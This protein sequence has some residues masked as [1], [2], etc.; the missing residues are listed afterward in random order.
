MSKFFCDEVSVHGGGCEY[1]GDDEIVLGELILG[2]CDDVV[3]I[4]DGLFCEDL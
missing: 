1:G 3:P 4:L 2:E